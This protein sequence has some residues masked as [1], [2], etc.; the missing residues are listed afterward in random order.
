MLTLGVTHYAW[1]ERT[2]RLL[3]PLPDGLYVQDGEGAPL[4]KVVDTANAAPALDPRF[5]PDGELIAYVQADEI[6]LVPALGGPARQ[7]THGAH[8]AGRTHGLAD[9]IAQEEMDRQQGYWWS[10]QGDWIA[11]E[12][13]DESHI[14]LYHIVHQGKDF[15][16][17]PVEEEHR[18]PF[19]GKA[20]PHVRLGLIP[21]AGG[22]VAWL[23]LGPDPDIYLARAGWLPDGRPWA[24]VENREQTSLDLLVFDPHT[25]QAQ[26]LLHEYQRRVDQPARHVPPL[27]GGPLCRR[28]HLGL[29]AH[30]L[31]PPLP[32]RCRRRPAAPAHR[33]AVRCRRVA[34]R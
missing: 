19:A 22:Q 7:L 28:L 12:E 9:Y 23:D 2:D 6:W 31:P 3:A 4:R 16:S 20:N 24:Q 26:R 13:V 10:P 5:S 1:A 33:P 30:W 8:A 34:G 18:Y 25:G 17:G 29:R 11:F 27:E 15:D 21:T 32:V 14:P